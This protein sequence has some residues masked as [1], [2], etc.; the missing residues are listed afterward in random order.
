MPLEEQPLDFV[1]VGQGLA[2]TT[3]AWQLKWRGLRGVI[4]DRDDGTSASKVAAGLMTPVT[5]KRLV[6]AW[7]LDE[8]WSA[9]DDFYRRVEKET[10]SQFLTQPGQVRLFDGED[11]KQEFDR[12]DWSKHPVEICQPSQLIN[13]E[14]FDAPFGGFE[15]PT[16]RRLD[17]P[18]Y[19]AASREAFLADGKLRI[20][21]LNPATDLKVEGDVVQLSKFNV[22]TG[23]LIFC[24]GAQGAENPWFDDVEFKS[25]RGEILTLRI[26][27][28]AE[29]RIVNQGVWL[30]PCGDGLFKAGS[31][32]DFDNLTWEVTTDGQ[33]EIV[34]RLKRFLKLP[35][36]IVGHESGVRPVVLERR[37][38][39]GIHR[40]FPQLAIF[41]GLGSKG[42]LLAPL[43][44]RE[45]ADYLFN[46]QA[47]DPELDYQE[48]FRPRVPRS[49]R[50]RIP[51]LTEQAQTLVRD[52]VQPGETAIDATAGNGHD[53]CFLAETVGHEGRVFAFDV[54]RDAL[55]RTSARLADVGYENVTLHQRS[56][57]EMK[58]VVL[59]ASHGSI[60]AVMFNLG[61]LPGGDH[62]VT[63]SAESS[64]TAIAV[65]LS[66][67]RSRGVV[68]VLAYPGHSGGDDEA[69]SVRQLLEEL[70]A[71]E[72]ESSIRRSAT[73]SETA[74]LL[75]VIVRR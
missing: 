37:P 11:S 70:P 43:V 7:R 75:F 68:T 4:I 14:S 63:T 20:S 74:P 36:E 5:G 42:S 6:P 61:Y 2:G 44:A 23:H 45:F 59:E 25:A 15:L 55:E 12:R 19:L 54:Q 10:K 16:A 38:I 24:Q 33:D 30:V 66:L 9:A 35:F 56:H 60:G 17:V 57:Q 62:A 41:N 52:V 50:P 22:T 8:T 67:V 73:T 69:G 13:T 3:L 53:T 31:T 64:L 32:Y 48:R 1:I 47:I 28:L 21:K 58:D 18:A 29:T 46:G 34:E 49:E 51:R 39:I 72:F 26:D 27:G 65:A 71:A 40:K